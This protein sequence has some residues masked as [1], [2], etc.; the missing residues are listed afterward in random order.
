[1]YNNTSSDYNNSC[2]YNYNTGSDYDNPC[3]NNDNTC[4]HND[5]ICSNY[6]TCSHN[7]NTCSKYNNTCSNYDNS[8]SY[9][10]NTSSYYDNTCSNYDNSCSHNYNTCSHY[11]SFSYSDNVGSFN[12]NT[13]SDYNNT[14]SNYDNTS[15]YYDNTGSNYS[16]TCSDYNVS[17]PTTTTPAP[18][19]T[20]PAPT[21]TTPAPTTTTPAPTTTSSA[22]TTTLTPEPVYSISADLPEEEFSND[23]TNRSSGR[24]RDLEKRVLATCTPIYKKR[25]PISFVRC[26]VQEFRP[27]TT[28]TRAQ[29]T[30]V[31]LEVVFNR[32]TPLAELPQNNVVA[33]ALVQGVN[34][35]NS[36]NVS[37]SPSS[38]KVE[39]GPV[40]STAATTTAAPTTGQAY[41]CCPTN[42][43][44]GLQLQ[45]T[46][47]LYNHTTAGFPLSTTRAPT[48]NN[49][50]R[51]QLRQ[52]G[53]PTTTTPGPQP[54][55]HRCP[56]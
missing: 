33:E 9:N 22:I 17:T 5:N 21:T 47:A 35:S 13:G 4:S 1:N 41:D 19:T 32:T 53:R 12:D 42:N 8:C 34:S 39:K 43:N 18:T 44:T 2:P 45:T 20:T 27:A 15:S 56:L 14:C 48:Y 51:L 31:D 11:N 40:P 38:V 24:F 28:Q 36:F 26:I 54:R 55:Q 49:N 7:D 37:I 52:P 10:Y 25:F 23:L 50:L 3:S 46:P 30:E 29:G 6:N 16:N